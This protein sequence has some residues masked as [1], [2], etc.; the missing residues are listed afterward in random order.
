MRPPRFRIRTLMIATATAG[1]ALG[2]AVWLHRRAE[3]FR[4]AAHY[5]E[6]QTMAIAIGCLHGWDSVMNQF[7]EDITR[8]YRPERDSWHR[9]LSTK[10]RYAASHPWLLVP[11][12]PPPP[13]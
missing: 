10:Y 8:S 4:R 2:V 11:P 12:D 7:G 13:E 6:S 3:E 5:H 9:T 1:V